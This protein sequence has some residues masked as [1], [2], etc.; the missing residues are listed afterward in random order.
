MKKLIIMTL[1][2]VS[3][4]PLIAELKRNPTTCRYSS[5]PATREI[6]QDEY[7]QLVWAC[8]DILSNYAQQHEALLAQ[9]P[10]LCRSS[11]Y[12]PDNNAGKAAVLQYLQRMATPTSLRLLSDLQSINFAI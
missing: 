11:S 5:I 10:D 6:N 1:M 8:K 12:D 2:I 3:I 4:S 7:H 9:Y